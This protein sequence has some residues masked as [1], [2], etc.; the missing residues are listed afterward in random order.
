MTSTIKDDLMDIKHLINRS[1]QSAHAFLPFL[2]FKIKAHLCEIE[3]RYPL[4][5]RGSHLWKAWMNIWA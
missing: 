4:G 1:R 2:T 3:P 5:G